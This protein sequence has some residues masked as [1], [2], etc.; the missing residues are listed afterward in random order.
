MYPSICW[1][2]ENGDAGCGW[3]TALKMEGFNGEFTNLNAIE[4]DE[5]VKQRNDDSGGAW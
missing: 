5:K 1:G 2:S 4:T 3:R